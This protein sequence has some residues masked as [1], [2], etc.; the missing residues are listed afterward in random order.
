[1]RDCLLV[2]N[3]L[4]VHLGSDCILTRSLI[5]IALKYHAKAP[6]LLAT[7]YLHIFHAMI[8]AD[9]STCMRRLP[10]SSSR[11]QTS[12]CQ[13]MTALNAI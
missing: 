6:T 3:A 8:T 4:L 5:Q 7:G 1:V 2:T 11:Y 13:L 12:Q 9:M 10:A